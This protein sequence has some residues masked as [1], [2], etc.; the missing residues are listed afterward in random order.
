MADFFLTENTNE[1]NLRRS[2]LL[3]SNWVLLK[4]QKKT[5]GDY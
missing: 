4:F 3:N 5:V 1:T 2:Q